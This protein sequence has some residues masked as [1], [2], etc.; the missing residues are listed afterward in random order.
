MSYKCCFA[1]ITVHVH[2]YNSGTCVFSQA[3][4]LYNFEF[5]STVLY[6]KAIA[7]LPAPRA[8]LYM[9]DNIIGL[10]AP[11]SMCKNKSLVAMLFYQYQVHVH[12]NE[13]RWQW[14][15]TSLRVHEQC[16]QVP[17]SMRTN[18]IITGLLAF[19]FYKQQGP[20]GAYE[21]PAASSGIL[22]VSRPMCIAMSKIQV[23]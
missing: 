15:F 9:S 19:L 22:P 20:L 18:N 1:S 12:I 3:S 14:Y 10:P 13:I 2:S 11:G 8:Q 7:C 21:S 6:P 17:V 5:F 4:G 16:C 23:W